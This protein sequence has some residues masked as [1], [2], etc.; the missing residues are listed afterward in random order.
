MKNLDSPSEFL[1]CYRT[2]FDPPGVGT[3]L[4]AINMVVPI[5]WV[6]LASNRSFVNASAMLR[7]IITRLVQERIEDVVAGKADRYLLEVDAPNEDLLTY[8]VKHKFLVDHD[9]WTKEELVEQVRRLQLS[10]YDMRYSL[11]MSCQALNFVATGMW[12]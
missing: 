8:M 3:V 7:Q 12:P 10:P 9:R 5:R 2:V 6:P 4:A 1:R 11:T